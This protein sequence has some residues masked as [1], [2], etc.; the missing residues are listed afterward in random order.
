MLEEG[1]RL[2]EV[3]SMLPLG[4]LYADH[5]DEDDLAEAT[6]RQGIEAGDV[7]CHNNLAVLLDQRG[8]TD[9][10]EMHYRLGA[11]AGDAL[12]LSGLNDLQ[13]RD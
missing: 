7:Y 9:R 8:E 10:A 3:K 6:Y 5:L 1:V 4:N 13:S 2:G 12:A 11:D